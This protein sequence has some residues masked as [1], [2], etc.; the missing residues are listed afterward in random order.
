MNKYKDYSVDEIEEH[1]S[2][3]I[4]DHWSFSM[5]QNFARNEKDFECRYIFQETH[6]SSVSTVSG[7]AYHAALELYFEALKDGV[8]LDI[9]QAE[10]TAF[11]FIDQWPAD[12]WKQS[13]KFDTIEKCVKE[14]YRVTKM[15]IGNFY[16]EANVYL[17]FI[18]KVLYVEPNIKV[19]ACVNGVDIPLPL[20]LRI[21]LIVET[22]EG[23][24][25]IIDHKSKRSFTDEKEAVFVNSKQAITYVL[26]AEEEFDIKID[27][28]YFIEN[29]FSKNKDNSSQLYK[30]PM[31][32]NDDFRKLNESFL[33]EPLKRM[34]KAISDPDYIYI[35]NDNDSFSDKAELYNFMAKTLI[36][37]VDDFNIDASNKDKIQKR[38]QKIK[39]T[40]I[41]VNA[42]TIERFK[43]KAASFIEY[44]LSSTNM[45]NEE[46]IEHILKSL[47]I[48][49]VVEKTFNGYSSNTYLLKVGAGT[50]IS[51][52]FKY[53]LDIANALGVPNVRMMPDLY[54]YDGKSYFAV[55]ASKQREKDLI[56]D[57]EY[58]IGG[59][60][61]PIG[62]DNFGNTV[63]W[64][65]DNPT[66][67]HM[68]VGG[69]TGSG[70]SVH[71]ISMIEYAKKL[72][73]KDIIIFD[74]KHEFLDFASTDVK[75]YNDIED[76]ETMLEL[77]VEEMESRIKKSNP[78]KTLVVFDEFADATQTARTK[79]EL[80][81]GEKT[82]EENLKL[83]LQKGRSSGFRIVACAQRPSVKVISGDAKVNFP[84]TVG[85]YMPK[86]I[87]SK[88]M[89]DENGAKFLSGF[90][91]GLIKS[92]EY[93]NVIRFQGF[94]VD[95]EN[96]NKK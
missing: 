25:A 50:K 55:E 17:S 10:K 21:D 72:G 20:H 31:K 7:N 33:Y 84:V 46:K 71:L 63:Y 38:I 81:E 92:P 59:M 29:K 68:L 13:K 9:I 76:L 75:V 66:T 48:P 87:D 51:S 8:S 28:V 61:I 74:P 65:L 3:Y 86:E 16:S 18:K 26:G 91:D 43:E 42:K 52:L 2:N 78:K 96:Y 83:L 53:K 35:M 24:I 56:W 4:L 94:I 14:S 49:C 39:S 11:E 85:F 36:A 5:V 23:K 90:G 93:L 1:F 58:L 45:T 6:K 15:L 62:I 95:K 60:K 12:K 41:H 82:L 67:P 89:L 19:W 30:I 27:E 22:I 64:D 79:K 54:Q 44:D 73:V 34:I 88:V 47:S 77:L 40:N 57:E 80:Q 69:A 70:K 37:E 32:V